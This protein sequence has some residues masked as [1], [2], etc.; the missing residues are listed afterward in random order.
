MGQDEHFDFFEELDNYLKKKKYKL[1]IL[2]HGPAGVIPL[3]SGH[4]MIYP[5]V[6]N[7]SVT[8]NIECGEIVEK[9][10]IAFNWKSKMECQ[11][12]AASV[13]EY[14]IIFCNDHKIS[15]D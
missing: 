3:Q 2:R 7:H 14:I 5:N 9:H 15:L 8:V 10:S 13:V 12:V 1:L 6:F 4:I 11:S